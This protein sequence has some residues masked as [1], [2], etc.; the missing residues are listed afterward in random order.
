MAYTDIDKPSDYFNTKLYSGTGNENT[1]SGVGFQPNFTWLKSRSNGQPHMVSDSVRGATKQLYTADN[2]AETSYSQYIKSFN[3]DGFVLGTDSGINQNSQTFVS[4]NWKA[5]TSF[6]NSAG[7]N[8]ASIA[9]TGSVSTTAGFS[10]GTYTGNATNNATVA[11]GLSSAPQMIIVK[12]RGSDGDN[13]QVYWNDGTERNGFL[14]LD[15]GFNTPAATQQWG[16]NVPTSSVFTLGSD[17]ATNVAGNL[18]FY[19]FHS[20]QGYSK[21][22]TYKGN[23]NANG[24]FFF[25]GFKVGFVMIKKT[26][27]SENWKIWDNKRPGFNDLNYQMNVNNNEAE[28]NSANNRLD[29][30]SNGFKL[31]G[32]GDTFNSSGGNYIFMAFAEQ[33]FVTSTGIPATAR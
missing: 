18:V 24:V 7:A 9:S 21:F 10:I 14:N 33:P 22:G 13:W 15:N 4:W 26:D 31:R 20:V 32:S 27:G 17:T 3:S 19:A 30:L 6:S 8:G 29:L 25:T 2:Q 1:I 12:Q 11:H 28:S 23:G 5:G 16:S